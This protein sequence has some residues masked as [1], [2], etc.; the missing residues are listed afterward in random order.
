[1]DKIINQPLPEPIPEVKPRKPFLKRF[2]RIWVILG[3]IFFIITIMVFKDNKHNQQLE[4]EKMEM[5][6]S[7]TL[8]EMKNSALSNEIPVC[9]SDTSTIFTKPFM[10]GNSPDFIVPMGSSSK[11]GHVVPVDHIYPI[12]FGN[13]KNIPVY[14]PSDLTLI[15]VENKQMH[16]KETEAITAAD[17]NLNFSP[18]RGINLVFIH[19]IKMSEKLDSAIEDENTNCNTDQKIDYGIQNGIPT[20]YQTCHPNFKKIKINAG[21]LIGYFS[22]KSEKPMSSFDIG[23][24]DYNKPDLGFANPARYY[25]ETNHTVCFADYYIP[26]LKD[27]YYAKFGSLTQNQDFIPVSGEPKCGKVMYDVVGTAAG[28]WFKNKIERNYITDNNALVLI[29]DNFQTE[30]A[31]FSLANVTSFT[32]SPTHSG[33]INREF[34]EVTADGN[35]YCYQ[36]KGSNT[37][38]LI[39]L[40]DTEHIMIESRTGVCQEKETFENPIV[41]ER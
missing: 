41:Y 38:Y 9:P 34:S 13:E 37:K 22:G 17:Y 11:D 40:V 30:L 31:K 6:K 8:N 16:N 26:E 7:G 2:W 24:Y 18:C 10:D 15:W 29:H 4:K 27:K 33:V 28:D 19:L 25:E 36:E 1:M 14:A 20:Y 3:I 12:N 32:F 23:L 21:E 39:Q 5:K 35:I